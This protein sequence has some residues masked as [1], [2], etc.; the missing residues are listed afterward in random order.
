VLSKLRDDWRGEN[1]EFQVLQRVSPVVDEADLYLSQPKN[2]EE[3][4][5]TVRIF[6]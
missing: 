3:V 2:L 1:A 6:E 4:Y 5:D